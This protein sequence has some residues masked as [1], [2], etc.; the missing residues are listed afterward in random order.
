[1]KRVSQL[2]AL[3]L[4]VGLAA[5]STFA[6]D[7]M[8]ALTLSALQ[9]QHGVAIDTRLS[10]FYNGWP[11]ANGGPQ[12]HEPQA[13]NLS[14]SWLGA[15]NDQ[16][17]GAWAARHRLQA[18]TPIALYGSDEDNARVAARLK[19]AGF[20][21]INTLSDA[22]S[23]PAR[24]QKLPHV[25]QL[26]YPQWLHDLQQGKAVAA[27]PAGQWKVF[28]AAWGAPKFYLLNHIPAAGYIDTNEVESEPLWNK[29]S[30][31]QL[32]ALLAK[33]RHSS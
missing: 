9:Q 30:D 32:Q 13:L 5:S 19:A 3:A 33:K 7:A 12:G 20:T 24:L 16:Q 25:E 18:A 31:A 8:P 15:M 29:V 6:A 28:E 11:Q 22:L 23:Q 27:A 2:T 26:V 10:A 17:L 1:M 4:L 21:H 14:A